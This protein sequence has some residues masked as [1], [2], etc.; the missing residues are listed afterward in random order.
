MIKMEFESI[1]NTLDGSLMLQEKSKF[2]A[3]V[4]IQCI[5]SNSNPS[6]LVIILKMEFKWYLIE[7]RM[8]QIE[9]ECIS[10]ASGDNY[11]E[12]SRTW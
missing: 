7:I 9:L 1:S 5:R 11:N 10:N 8:L 2:N 12:D 3:S 6:S 4:G